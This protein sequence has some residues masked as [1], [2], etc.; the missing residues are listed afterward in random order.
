MAEDALGALNPPVSAALH[1]AL[2]V[3][4]D[5]A[6]IGSVEHKLLLFV[7]SPSTQWLLWPMNSY[8][9]LMV[10]QLA[11]YYALGH[12]VV[13]GRVRV[14]KLAP[15]PLPLPLVVRFPLVVDDSTTVV[16][17]KEVL[18]S[19]FTLL[20]RG[21]QPAAEEASAT[22]VAREEKK[23]K[24]MTLPVDL[25]TR[26]KQY[27]QARERIFDSSDDSSDEDPPPPPPTTTEQHTIS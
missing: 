14:F 17:K 2:T 13:D 19:T 21:S 16:L 15:L 5:H 4:A 27:Q 20:K 22:A 18:P 12:D 10:H 6:F 26:E 23:K 1:R 24:N 11:D 7:R 8:R 9:R 25:A 3:A